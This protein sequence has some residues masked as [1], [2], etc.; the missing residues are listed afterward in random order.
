[1]NKILFF[2]I[3]AFSVLSL[4][5]TAQAQIMGPSCHL[6]VTHFA[7]DGRVTQA[8]K[9]GRQNRNTERQIAAQ[10]RLAERSCQSHCQMIERE[11]RVLLDHG[12]AILVECMMG[13]KSLYRQRHV[14]E[15]LPPVIRKQDME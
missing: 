6:Q 13:R 1:M 4:T 10:G 11:E 2:T 8:Q 3:L 9:T 14:R 7:N 12:E 5:H 15:V